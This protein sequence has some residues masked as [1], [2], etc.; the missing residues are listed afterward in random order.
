MNVRRGWR[1][2]KTILRA[3]PSARARRIVVEAWRVERSLPRRFRDSPL[4]E[5]MQQLDDEA[6]AR[7]LQSDADSIVRYADAVALLDHFSPL[8]MCLR[9]SLVRYALLRAAGVPVVVRFGAKKQASSGRSRIAG[10]A[11]LTLAGEPL[12][13]NPRDYEGFTAIYTYPPD[14]EPLRSARGR[15]ETSGGGWVRER[16][17]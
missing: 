4:P 14:E 13:E 15:Q 6:R 2:L 5:L 12:A 7:T 3:L 16:N 9:R 17:P 8:G 1:M 10:H 11:W